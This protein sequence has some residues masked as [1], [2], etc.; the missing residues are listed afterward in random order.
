MRQCGLAASGGAG[1]DVKREFRE[2][3]AENLIEARNP[4]RQ[5]IDRYFVW[6]GHSSLFSEVP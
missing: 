3:T 5:F 1:D 4:S 2:T 6:W